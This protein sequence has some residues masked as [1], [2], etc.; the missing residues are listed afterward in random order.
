MYITS[1]AL[2]KFPIP[3]SIAIAA[4]VA[5]NT[6]LPLEIYFVCVY[7]SVVLSG[8]Y[9]N[10]PLCRK[11]IGIKIPGFF[12]LYLKQW[13]FVNLISSLYGVAMVY[14]H[15]PLSSSLLICYIRYF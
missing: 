4:G 5:Y 8:N 14:L 2:G 6:V 7:V 3:L 13:Q 1:M 15:F 10:F 11:W 9:I 12:K